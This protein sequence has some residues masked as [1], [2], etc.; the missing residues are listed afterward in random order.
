[1]R[2]VVVSHYFAPEIGAPSARIYEMAKRWI[3]EGHRVQVIT[4]FPNHPTGIIPERYR[5]MKYLREEMDGITVH[6]SYIYATPNKGFIKRT[7]GHLSFVVSSMIYSMRKV[8]EIDVVIST[9]PTFFSMFSGYH[10]S[11]KKK[12][13]WILEIRDLWPAAIDALGVLKNK[14]ILK[15]LEKIELRFYTLCDRIV[16]V[17]QSFKQNLISRGVPE[18]KIEVITNGFDEEL[19][20]PQPKN[21]ALLQQYE[22]QDKFIVTYIGAHGISHA[23]DKLILVAEKLRKQKDIQFVFVGEGAE[24]D[25]LIKMA[26][27]KNLNNILFIDA[28]PKEHMP[29]YYNLSDISIVTLKKIPLFKSFIPSKI[30]EI[31]GCGIPIIASLEGETADILQKSGA[32]MIV[33]PEDVEAITRA[34]EQIKSDKTLRSQMRK[35]GSE[36]VNKYYSRTI[37]SNKYIKIIHKTVG[38]PIPLI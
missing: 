5:G 26:Q 21:Q 35:N 38:T 8:G 12:V 37:L 36:Y 1:M 28:Q 23:L 16:V 30:F 15:L 19:Y 32:A 24:K 11:K 29:D 31:M 25:K 20:M 7:I 4:G 17:T 22:L 2:I 27:E 18:N 6:R 13:P 9:S 33:P 14:T 10:L 34:I 3:R